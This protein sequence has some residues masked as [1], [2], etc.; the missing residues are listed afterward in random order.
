MVG[1][2][3]AQGSAPGGAPRDPRT[4]GKVQMSHSLLKQPG[5]LRVPFPVPLAPSEVLG[6]L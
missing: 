3:G 2:A 1:V 5:F 4:D 6:D